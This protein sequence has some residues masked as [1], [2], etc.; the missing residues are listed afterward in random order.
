MPGT[1]TGGQNQ[2]QKYLE[3]EKSIRKDTI[4]SQQ[5]KYR[6]PICQKRHYT[7]QAVMDCMELNLKEYR[8]KDR[9]LRLIKTT[10]K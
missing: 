1:Q 2:F 6:C 9:R 5:P 8:A 10:I 3:I 4:M 7:R